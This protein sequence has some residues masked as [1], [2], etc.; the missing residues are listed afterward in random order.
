MNRVV[1]IRSHYPD[2]RLEKEAEVLVKNGY[3][4][5]LLVWDRGRLHSHVETKGYGVKRMRLSVS[6]ASIKVPFYLPIWWLFVIFQLSIEK[7]DIVHAAD[8]DTLFPALIV[9]KIK[10]KP[11]IYDIFDFYAD[12]I[13]FP[14]L[15]R[16]SRKIIAKIDRFF[17]DFVN[18]IILPD[19]SRIEQIGKN[20]NKGIVIIVNSPNE[21]ILNEVVIEE[22]REKKFT[23]F[24]GGGIDE[25]RSI[26][27]VSLAVKDLY[28]VEL[29]IMGPCT[30]DYERKLRETC[31][32]IKIVKL[33][34]KWI[35]YKEI[36]RQTV[37]VDLLFALYDPI[38]FNNKY[39]SPNKLFEAMMCGK[40]IIVS[41]GTSMADI[42]REHN[43]GIVVDPRDVT[44]IRDAII[45]LKDNP[46]LCKE[47]GKNGRRAYE[48][49]YNWSIM[50][51]RLLNLYREL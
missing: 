20:S 14:I 13:A 48:E 9:G 43:C 3:A 22:K 4:V 50:E 38:I 37:D 7:W 1:M 21:D 39:A 34:L 25:D 24:F 26:D 41:D 17:M 28:D 19:G 5:T 8:F 35:P 45:K 23:I 31:K 40:P 6:P 33:F 42:V 27:K 10:R 18:I 46:Q 16:M 49:K 12:M 2:S 11:I 30:R 44:E 36:I 15:P 47:L 29:I 32:N 51:K